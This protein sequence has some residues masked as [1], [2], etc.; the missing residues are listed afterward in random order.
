MK[1]TRLLVC[2]LTL[3]LALLSAGFARQ[4]RSYAADEGNSARPQEP[5]KPYPYD[6]EEVSYENKGGGV[7]LAGTL[8][9]PRAKGPFPVVVLIT[10]SGPQNRNEELLG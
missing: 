10:G 5:K 3:V 8:T 1:R 7:K 2:S 9:L 4:F 6:E